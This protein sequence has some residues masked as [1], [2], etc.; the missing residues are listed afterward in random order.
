MDKEQ[1]PV[2]NKEQSS[3]V[4]KEKHPGRVAQGHKL[5]ALMK[6]R[7]EELK[8]NKP[9][10]HQLSE[11]SKEQHEKPFSNTT[12]YGAGIALVAGIALFYFWNQKTEKTPPPAPSTK[13]KISDEEFYRMN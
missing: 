5:A 1:T 8:Q 12:L 7:K 2:V 9:A 10:E 13:P 6:Q 4:T 11:Q 3:V